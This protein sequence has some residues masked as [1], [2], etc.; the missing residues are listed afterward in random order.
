[1]TPMECPCDAVKELK[2]LVER[3]ERQLNDG[4]VQFA[5][6]QQDLGWIKARLDEKKKFNSGIL[7]A[8]IQGACAILMAYVAA[9]I[10]LG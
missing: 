6:I 5:L 4:N 10:G 3:H 2:D 8:I 7:S 9:K 1:M